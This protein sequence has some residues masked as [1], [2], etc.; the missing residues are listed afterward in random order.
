[1]NQ[2]DLAG[3]LTRRT[4]V[5]GFALLMAGCATAP[6]TSAPTAPVERAPVAVPNETAL[7][8]DQ[9]RHRVALL[10]PLTGRNAAVGQ[11]IANA[12][13]MA[14]LDTG[15]GNLRITNYDTAGVGGSAGAAQRAMQDGN[16]LILGPLMREE[17]GPVV[18]AART[19]DVPVLTF[20]NDSDLAGSGVFVMGQSPEQSIRRSINFARAKGAG[21]FAALVPEGEYGA[22]ALAAFQRAVTAAQGRTLRTETYARNNTSILSSARRIRAAGEVDAVFIAD[23]PEFA[24]R[25]ARE[26]GRGVQIIGTELWSGDAG[27]AQGGA[28]DGAIFSAVSDSRYRQFVE[29]YR[30]RFDQAPYRVATLGYD[31]VLLA[32][33]VGNAWRFGRAFPTRVLTDRQGF[34]GLDGVFRFARN[35]IVERAMEVRQVRGR[36]VAVADPAPASF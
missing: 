35:G 34:L 5:A 16:G 13:T 25:A 17:V 23:S 1:M 22:R 9:T 20:S 2:Q 3:R 29:S 14:L 10:V 8:A 33:N 24:A 18:A 11:S 4:I 21:T 36:E 15:A 6:R 32:L 30:A 31:G 12:T 27:V 26:L 19:R 28:L 7:P